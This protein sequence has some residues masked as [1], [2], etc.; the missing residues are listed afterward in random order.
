MMRASLVPLLLPLL[1]SVSSVAGQTPAQPPE[2]M[3]A[4][5][6][7][8]GETPSGPAIVAGPTEIRIGG[9]LGITGIYRSTA[10]GGGPGTGFATL[11]YNDTLTGNASEARLSAQPSRLS[12]RVNAAPAPNRSTLAGYFEMDF[13]GGVPGNVAVTSTSTE[14]RLRHAFGE[15]QFDK[16]YLI[17]AGQAY[18]LMTPPRDQLSIWP[19]DY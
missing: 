13:A 3:N 8:A 7:V 14:F 2:Q 11:P 17:A 4:T 18:S 5:Q 1:L 9:Y 10:N 6:E 15:A 16:R 12:I 19:S